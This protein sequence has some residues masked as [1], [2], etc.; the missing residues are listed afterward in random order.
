M[1]KS[2]EQLITTTRNGTERTTTTRKQ[3]WEKNNCMDISSDKL[4]NSRMRRP[5]RGKEKET[6]REKLNTK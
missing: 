5:G 4:M 2:K 1:K 3:K 6:L